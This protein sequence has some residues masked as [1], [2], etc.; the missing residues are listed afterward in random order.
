MCRFRVVTALG[1]SDMQTTVVKINLIPSQG[2][3]FRGTKPMPVCDQDHGGVS[4]TVAGSLAGG[5][6][7]PLDLFFGHSLGRSSE[8][9][10]LRGT[11]RFTIG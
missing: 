9:G 3:Q 2:A 1:P 6:L 5:F 11:I 4:M 10:A 7:E 8:F